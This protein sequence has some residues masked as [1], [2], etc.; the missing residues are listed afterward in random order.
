MKTETQTLIPDD[1]GDFCW[2]YGQHFFIE[3][4]KGNFI[5][6]D[7]GY[8]GDNTI[9]PYHGTLGDYCKEHHLPYLRDKGHHSI[10][11][12]CGDKVKICH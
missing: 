7:P 12:Y 8:S 1:Y 9:I 3:T 10:K 11:G 2:D 4:K 6:S 5:W